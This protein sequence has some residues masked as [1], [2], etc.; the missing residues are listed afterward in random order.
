MGKEKFSAEFDEKGQWIETEQDIPYARLPEA[1]KAALKAE[2]A[3]YRAD[4]VELVELPEGRFY[5]VEL[6]P[7]KKNG[8]R[9]LELLLSA[10]GKTIRKEEATEAKEYGSYFASCFRYAQYRV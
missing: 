5:E 6:E 3:A 9:E 7:K 2:Y 1:V 8:G 10:D 4:E